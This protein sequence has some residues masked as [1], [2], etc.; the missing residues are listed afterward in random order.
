VL[1]SYGDRK[2]LNIL[3]SY[4]NSVVRLTYMISPQEK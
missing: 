4:Y 1:E 3:S 2:T